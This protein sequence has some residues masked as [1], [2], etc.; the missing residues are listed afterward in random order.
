MEML[1]QKQQEIQARAAHIRTEARQLFREHGYLGL[2]MDRIASRLGVAKGTIYQH[3]RNKEEIV[4]ALAIETLEKRIS[5]FE[6]AAVFPGTPRQRM[7]AIGCAAEVFVQQYPD[8][9]ELEKV[10]SCGSIIEKT[11]AKMQS[12]RSA[13]ELRCISMLAGIVRDAI[14]VGDLQ[15]PDDLQ[16]D[17]LVF[18]LWSTTYGG[19]S[20]I[21]G[22]QTMEQIGIEDGFRMVR[23]I[24][25]RLLDGFGWKPLSTRFDYNATFDQVR[26]EIFGLD[27]SSPRGKAA[28]QTRSAK[29]TKK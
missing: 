21:A 29:A 23:E 19:Y 24:N 18:G 4:L 17:H 6:R 13:T 26:R 5:L 12:S 22:Q 11:G 9:F 15:L 7:A 27:A 16:P 25:N 28:R 14:A 20:I 8:H 3:Y 10:L 2:N 1:S